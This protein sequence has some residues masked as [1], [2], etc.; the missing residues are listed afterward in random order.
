MTPNNHASQDR[1]GEK[2]PA[3]TLGEY[4]QESPLVRASIVEAVHRFYHDRVL[5]TKASD[6]QELAESGAADMLDKLWNL[7]PDWRNVLLTVPQR[8]SGANTT[9]ASIHG[10][11]HRDSEFKIE[12][13]F[14]LNSQP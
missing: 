6:R 2:K 5:S 11:P 14:P 7:I 8:Y 10:K 4:V 12:I 3:R 9:A 1:G 13:T